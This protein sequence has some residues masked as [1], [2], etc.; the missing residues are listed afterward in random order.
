MYHL[1]T[2]GLLCPEPEMMLHNKIRDMHSGECVKVLATD[3]SST[4]DVPKFCQ[5]LGHQ[6]VEHTEHE[7][8]FC[9]VIKKK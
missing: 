5:F 3:P 4:R 8:T 9:F 7:G 6:L 2:Q 1:D